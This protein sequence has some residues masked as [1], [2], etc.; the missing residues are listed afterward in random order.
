MAARL[1]VNLDEQLNRKLSPTAMAL[2]RTKLPWIV[3][4]SQRLPDEAGPLSYKEQMFE[5]LRRKILTARLKVTLDEQLNRETFATVMA[6]SRMKLPPIVL[7]LSLAVIA[8]P[9]GSKAAKGSVTRERR[10]S[11]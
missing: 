2:S 8:C 9:T 1:K 3:V 10:N 7:L 4:P 5:R 6:L 11:R